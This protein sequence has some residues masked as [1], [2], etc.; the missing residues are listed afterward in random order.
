[1]NADW[2]KVNWNFD[3]TAPGV[4]AWPRPMDQKSILYK[5]SHVAYQMKDN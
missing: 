5:Y 2:R 3:M 4:G 1:M